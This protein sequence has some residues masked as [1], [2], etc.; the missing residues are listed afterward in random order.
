MPSWTPQK[1]WATEIL[2]A[3]DLNTYLR[4]DL[5]YLKGQR[6]L[7]TFSG[8]QLNRSAATSIPNATYDPVTWSG[9][10][11]D[12]GGWWSSGAS[13]IVPA[14]AVPSGYTTIMLQVVA[15]TVFAANGTGIRKVRLLKNGASFGSLS[16]SAISGDTT[17]LFIFDM[18]K[19]VAA[20]AITMQLYQNSGGALDASSTQITVVRFGVLA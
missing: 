10:V 8:A 20:D 17:D 11:W 3:S 18:E 15:R 13:V 5:E 14:G 9:E 4:D 1:T 2:T 16:L 12:Y 19:A 6:D 7:V